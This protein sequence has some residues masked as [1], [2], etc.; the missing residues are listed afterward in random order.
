MNPMQ[1][2]KVENYRGMNRL[3]KK[4][5]ILFTGS[6]LMEGFPVN[7]YEVSLGTGR[8]VYNRGIGGTTTDDFL[9]YIDDVLFDLAPRKV[10]F[11]IGTNDIRV[12]EDGEDWQEHILKNYEKILTQLRERLPETEVY[13]MAFYPVNREVPEF[14]DW[15]DARTN[16]LI[17]EINGKIRALTEKH[18]M[19]FID[20]NDGLKDEKGNLKAEI[21]M[22]GVHIY[23][24]GYE[25]VYEALQPYM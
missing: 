9:E 19:H 16:P 12:R 20:V 1:L 11:N 5:E 14:P 4:G 8:V 10:F 24:G 23:A 22:E 7:E 3:A 13:V 25:S 15:A 6:S 18:G 2:V 21:T 17:D